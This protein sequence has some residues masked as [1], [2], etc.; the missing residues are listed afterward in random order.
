MIFVPSQDELRDALDEITELR[1]KEKKWSCAHR[2]RQGEG[3]IETDL[4]VEYPPVRM[5]EE[6]LEIIR[7]WQATMNPEALTR[8]VCAV[9]AQ[10][11]EDCLL[12]DVMPN[13]QML[14]LL[15][16]ECLPVKTLPSM[17]DFQLYH[18]AVLQPHGMKSLDTF[19]DLQMCSKCCS[20]LTKKTPVLPKDAI[21]NFQYYGMSELPDNVREAILMASPFKVMLV[22]LCH[23]TVITHHYQSKSLRGRL[24]DEASQCF[25]RGNVAVLPQDHGALRT[26]LP[27]AVDDIEGSVCIVFAGGKFTPT[28][29]TLKRF[30]P[31]LI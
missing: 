1:Q 12:Y 14:V 31:V 21:A 24:P 9:C 5:F 16:N 23:A 11:F 25:N 29:E 17:Y 6:K 30:P 22:A 7:Q 10:E 27:P 3:E 26:I 4:S 28:R 20:A 2:R 8:G 18:C 15:R 13:E 19:A